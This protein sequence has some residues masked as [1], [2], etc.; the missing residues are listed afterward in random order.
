MF[1]PFHKKIVYYTLKPLTF[2]HSLAP[3]GTGG[4][5]LI[6]RANC[7]WGT[8]RTCS[9]VGCPAPCRFS[10]GP[11]PQPK[12]RSRFGS[13]FYTNNWVQDGVQF[14]CILSLF[15]LIHGGGVQADPTVIK[16]RWSC[17]ATAIIIII[18][19]ISGHRVVPNGLRDRQGTFDVSNA[20]IYSSN[21][22][23]ADM[24]TREI[25][26]VIWI[27]LNITK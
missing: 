11:D 23:A 27:I 25:V 18:I 24:F 1:E 17:S 20:N 15:P 26:Q 4:T 14:S 13:T 19:N 12:T 21:E 10:I 9:Q 2:V 3:Y 6:R 8:G 16:Q 5:S 22:S 7:F